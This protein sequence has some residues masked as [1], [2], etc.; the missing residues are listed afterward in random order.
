MNRLRLTATVL[1]V[2]LAHAD[3]GKSRPGRFRLGFPLRVDS[4]SATLR[5]RVGPVLAMAGDLSDLV[6]R[7]FGG[8]DQGPTGVGR[9]IGPFGPGVD[10]AGGCMC[11]GAIGPRG[12]RSGRS[13]GAL[14]SQFLS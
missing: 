1:T 14:A 8:Q 3:C 9:G 13:V 6:T 2:V 5:G 4:L 12:D 7:L 11:G 10:G